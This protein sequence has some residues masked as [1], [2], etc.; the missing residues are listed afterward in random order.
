MEETRARGG[1]AGEG[2]G[3]RHLPVLCQQ[4][5]ACLALGPGLV[6]VDCT[7]G[8]AGHFSAVASAISPGG[9]AVG[10]DRDERAL[11]RARAK[12]TELD[13]TG[14][15]VHLV[16]ADYRELRRVIA[17]FGLE[18]VDRVLFDLGVSSDQIDDP[19]RGFSFLRDG[20]LDMRLDTSSA[21]TAAVVVNEYSPHALE[22]VIS[23]YGEERYAKRIAAAIVARRKLCPFSSTLDLAEVVTRALP[24][25]RG[26]S[27]PATRTFQALRI[28][29]GDELGSL[30]LGMTAAA[31][32]LSV[33][34]RIAVITFH[35]LEDRIVKQA[36]RPY[37]RH[38][39]RSDWYVVRL[40][41]VIEA[42]PAEVKANPRS[43]SAKLR[44][45]QKL[46]VHQAGK[47]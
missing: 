18:G 1:A 36:L 5:V 9:I 37:S 6:Y 24:G 12:L 25:G 20:P 4:V 7:L 22:R 2:P 40:G 23:E 29:V 8:S 10:I 32:L 45:Y 44:V 26:K 30:A 16:H 43:R 35:S 34:G 19:E 42:D 21:L 27:H 47:G 41:N 39:G 13:A 33:T 28:E 46:L 3:T 15:V 38:A 31:E 11:D 17:R 14:V